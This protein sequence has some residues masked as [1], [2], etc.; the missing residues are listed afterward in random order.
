MLTDRQTDHLLLLFY[1]IIIILAI[2]YTSYFT[3]DKIH[4]CTSDPLKYT[5]N[6]YAKELGINYTGLS[7][8]LYN[9]IRTIKEINIGNDNLTITEFKILDNQWKFP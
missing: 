2:I 9:G 5:A 3:L 8:R 1:F 6:Y 7:F 4:S